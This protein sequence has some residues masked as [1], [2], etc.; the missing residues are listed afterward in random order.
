MNPWVSLPVRTLHRFD[1]QLVYLSTHPGTFMERVTE[2]GCSSAFRWR[3]RPVVLE[4]SR[5]PPGGDRAAEGPHPHSGGSG[6][7]DTSAAPGEGVVW[8]RGPEESA[9]WVFQ[10]DVDPAPLD[11][12]VEGSPLEPLHRVYRGFKPVVMPDPF[13]GMCWVILSQQV[14]VTFAAKLKRVLVEH[15]GEDLEEGGRTWKVFPSPE[16]LAALKPEDL[17]PFQF[18]RQKAQYLVDLARRLAEGW[19]LGPFYNMEAEEAVECLT[20]LRGVGRWSAECFLLFAFRH[21]DV[22]PAADLGLRRALGRL[23]GLGRPATEEEVRTFGADFRGWRSYVA[24]YL[25]LALREGRL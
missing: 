14:N 21:P 6:G 5:V 12:L 13:Q 15:F 24:Q 17:R 18:S 8:L 3:G 20:R 4:V 11:R 2:E 25:W 23:L 9:R 1:L 10:F 16:R 7:A 22:L 19:D